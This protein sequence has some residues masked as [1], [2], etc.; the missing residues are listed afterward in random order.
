MGGGVDRHHLRLSAI[1]SP[2]PK[3]EHKIDC[4]ADQTDAAPIGFDF[5][6]KLFEDGAPNILAFH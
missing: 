4:G 5:R 6:L 1:S 2:T 3:K